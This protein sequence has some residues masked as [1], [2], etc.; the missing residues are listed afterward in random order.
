MFSRCQSPQTQS[1]CEPVMR[2]KSEPPSNL[3][4]HVT[5]LSVLCRPE[6]TDVCFSKDYRTKVSLVESQILLNQPS[7]YVTGQD[8]EKAFRLGFKVLTEATADRP[9]VHI[10]DCSN[11]EGGTAEAGRCYM[12]YIK[13]GEPSRLLGFICSGLSPELKMGMELDKAL[14]TGSSSFH[15]AKDY[16]EAVQLALSMLSNHEPK[17]CDQA[18]RESDERYRMLIEESPSAVSMIGTD[19]CYKYINP[20][21]VEIFGYTL[22][23]IP[24]GREWFEK[25][26]PDPEDRGEVASSWITDRKESKAG[27]VRP[28]TFTV[29]CKDGSRKVVHFR[30]VTLE[31]GDQFV[32]YEDISERQRVEQALEKAR[33]NL[34]IRVAERTSELIRANERLQSEI[35]EREGAEKALRE[36]EERFRETAD[37]LPTIICE[38]DTKMRVT[39]VNDLGL[40]SFGYSRADVEAYIHGLDLIHPDHRE[41]ASRRI[42]RIMGGEKLEATEYKMLRKDGSEMA[43]LLHSSPMYKGGSLVG[44]RVSITDVTERKRL[45]RQFQQAQKMEAVG[46]L[47]GGIAHDFNNLLMGIQGRVSLMLMGMDDDHAHFTHVS[48]IEEAVKRGAYLAK[49]LLGFARGG[50]YEVKP[51]DLNDL[52]AKS[53]EMLGRAKKEI[54][55]RRKHEKDIWTVE[56]DRGQIEQVL[57]NLYVNAWQAMPEGGDLY[58]E[59]KNVRLDKKYT[60][61]FHV[62]PGN[63][64]KISAT[65]T[66]VGMD[67]ATRQRVFEPFFTTKEIGGGTG[68]GLASAYGIINNHGG[69]I[70][71]Y[72]EPG[73]G[74]TFNIYLPASDKEITKDKKPSADLLKGKETVLLVDDEHMVINVGKEMLTALS[75]KVMIAANGEEAVK[76]YEKNRDKIDIVVL[77]LIMP[78]MGGGEVYDRIKEMNPKVKVLLSS[79]YSIDGQANEI[80]IRGCDGFIQKPF[81]IK[82]LSAS[83]RDILEKG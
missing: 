37:L 61:A 53:S 42:A 74:A 1:P 10:E 63:Y 34:E 62:E 64:V 55:I 24:T 76:I 52:V 77:D 30:P 33:D 2:R 49:Q 3:T 5:G 28:R 4:C 15:M 51:T 41:K 26:F 81:N 80:L 12:D 6:W 66:G 59:T 56:I 60:K 48:G 13:K 25:A 83:L 38:M 19:G 79:G 78:D 68:L 11:L 67:E 54:K 72:S 39:Y 40:K 69:I 73:H 58:L 23:D 45:E 44:M 9:Y 36:S 29:T 14:D 50:K 31:S 32:F 17:G 43:V 18:L 22:E 82:E 35:E 16:S 47:A 65:D 70:D 75:Y 46:T 57:L 20:K 71:V 27:E 21:F 7:G 8:A